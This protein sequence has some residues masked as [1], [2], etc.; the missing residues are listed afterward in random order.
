MPKKEKL[1]S[2]YSLL[3][4]SESTLLA[5]CYAE[6]GPT[7]KLI[8]S[9]FKKSEATLPSKAQSKTYDHKIYV[10]I[11]DHHDAGSHLPNAG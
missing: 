7:H 6:S 4:L 1:P 5:A 3:L 11:S 2:S 8:E 9:P 10:Y